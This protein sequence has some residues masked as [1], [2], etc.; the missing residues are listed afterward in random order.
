MT[1][2]P[3]QRKQVIATLLGDGLSHAGVAVER[4]GG[5][6]SARKINEFDDLS[7]ASTSFSASLGETAA[8][9]SRVSAVKADTVKGGLAAKPFS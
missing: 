8:R 6:Q 3:L 4:V 9:H 1:A 5:D 2:V 7:A